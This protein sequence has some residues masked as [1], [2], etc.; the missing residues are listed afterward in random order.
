MD[1]Y[2][3]QVDLND[4]VTATAK[5]HRGCPISRPPRRKTR[6]LA[7]V[8]ALLGLQSPPTLTARTHLPRQNGRL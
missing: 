3:V 1:M 2:T 4:A 5:Q 8:V 7:V 6:A